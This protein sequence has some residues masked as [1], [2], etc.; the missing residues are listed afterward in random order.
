MPPRTGAQGRRRQSWVR[1]VAESSDAMD[2]PRGIFKRSA[3]GIA[4]GLKTSVERSRRTKGRT[5][6][7][8]AMGMLNLYVNRAGRGLGATERRRLA[9]A[10]K[11][12]R[13]VFHREPVARAKR[14]A[15]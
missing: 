13:K 15:A 2:L 4:R 3:R 8:S 11:E 1:K 5:K 9:A 12:L 14:R 10:K 6:F 7:Q